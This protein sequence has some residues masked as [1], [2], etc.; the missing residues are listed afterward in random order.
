MKHP[1]ASHFLHVGVFCDTSDVWG[2]ELTADEIET[3]QKLETKTYPVI[4]AYALAKMRKW[5][6][7]GGETLQ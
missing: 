4:R 1:L 6:E 2:N 7:S 3:F 5:L